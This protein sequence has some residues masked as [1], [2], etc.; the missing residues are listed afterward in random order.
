MQKIRDFLLQRMNSLKK[1]MTNIQ[2]IQQSVLLKYKGLYKFLQEHASEVAAEVKEAYTTTMSAIYLRHVKGYLA[3]LMRLR[4]E[5]ATKGDLLGNEE[6]GVGSY[7][8][9]KPATA[10]GDGAYKLGERAAVL[11]A[12][13]E[14]P[15]IPAVLQQ[16]GT[17]VHY[18]VRRSPFGSRASW[19]PFGSPR[20]GTLLRGICPEH[21]PRPA[22]SLTR[23]GHETDLFCPPAS[24][25]PS[26][27]PL[28]QAVFRSVS[29]LLMDAVG[30]EHDFIVEFFGT[31]EVPLP[32]RLP[33][34]SRPDP[35]H[36]VSTRSSACSPR[37]PFSHSRQVFD[38]IFGKAIFH[39]MENLEQLLI[40]SWD[41]VGCLL[42]LQLNHEQ[43]EIMSARQMPLLSSF[44]Q[45]AQV[46]V[47]SRFKVVMEA[48]LQSLVAF[49]PP[50]VT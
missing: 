25:T 16:A 31:D 5:S 33:P 14:A 29:T 50:K 24:A 13:H 8:A 4:I 21:L 48:H 38:N 40:G 6:W 22:C 26:P 34:I 37:P 2:I 39:C 3:D 11:S 9:T 47:W 23:P 43:R 42:L 12:V 41:A 18:E 35:V 49:V 27:R 45:R 1:K 10:R 19:P 36:P 20:R 30:S 32:H 46:L 28:A 17:M 15:L 44:F 7:F